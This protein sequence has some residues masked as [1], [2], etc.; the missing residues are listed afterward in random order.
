MGK[1]TL[2]ILIPI[3]AAIALYGIITQQI[4]TAIFLVTCFGVFSLLMGYVWYIISILEEHLHEGDDRNRLIIAALIFLAGILIS[5]L[6]LLGVMIFL[7]LW[8]WLLK[9]CTERQP[10]NGGKMR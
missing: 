6:L 10:D 3:I 8:C 5:P 2:I 9:T 4:L 1:K 7:L